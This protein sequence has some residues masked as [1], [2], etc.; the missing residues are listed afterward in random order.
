MT[1]REFFQGSPEFLKS[2]RGTVDIPLLRKDFMIDERQIV[3]AVEWGG[4]RFC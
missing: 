1:D 3:E 4:T 2:V